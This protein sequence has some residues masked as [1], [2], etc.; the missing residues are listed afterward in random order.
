[1]MTDDGQ[2]AADLGQ[3]LLTT[4]AGDVSF[5]RLTRELYST[6]ASNYR[7]VPLGVVLPRNADDIC[8]VLET[9]AQF[10]VPVLPRGGGTSLS[11]QTVGR[12][13]ILDLSRYLDAILEES[14]EE[15]WVRV[16]PG[17]VLDRLNRYLRPADLMVGPDPAS[18]PAATLGGM[19]GNN[20]T[21]MHSILYGMTA[22][23]VLDLEVTLANGDQISVGPSN[24]LPEPLKSG[25]EAILKEY[26][27]EIE[28]RYPKTRRSVAGYPLNKLVRPGYDPAQLFVGSEGTLGVITAAKIGLVKRPPATRLAV[29]QFEALRPALEIVPLILETGPSAIELN[30]R[31]FLDLTRGVPA[32]AKRLT[33]VDGD[34]RCLLVVE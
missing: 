1:M 20:S 17:V 14:L 34:P 7:V 25:L 22:D 8:A 5:D 3:A 19:M 15:H 24:P 2:L 26:E 33:F 23:H 30:D 18:S 27:P 13:I 32:F 10:D 9:A 6:D 12:A 21:G 11:G 16:Q 31:F 4:I 28:T 29:L